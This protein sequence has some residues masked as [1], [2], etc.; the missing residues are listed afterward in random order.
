MCPFERLFV[1]V[2]LIQKDEL[3]RVKVPG[4]DNETR[5]IDE[6]LVIHKISFTI[7]VTF[8]AFAR[9]DNFLRVMSFG[10]KNSR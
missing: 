3:L 1:D 7:W 10:C 9:R 2:R 4:G 6:Y 8:A 5:L